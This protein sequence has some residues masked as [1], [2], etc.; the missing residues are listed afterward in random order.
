MTKRLNWWFSTFTFQLHI[1]TYVMGGAERIYQKE[2]SKF[3]HLAIDTTNARVHSTLCFHS[4]NAFLMALISSSRLLKLGLFSFSS[5][6]WARQSDIIII[7]MRICTPLGTN[8]V[9]FFK[10]KRQTACLPT[11]CFFLVQTDFVYS[12]EKK[13][14]HSMHILCLHT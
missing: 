4:P 13:C 11:T 14:V 1:R 3:D 7:I 12:T 10:R 5:F 9:C 8:Q 6:F 2:S